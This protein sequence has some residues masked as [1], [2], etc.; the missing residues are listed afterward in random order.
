[1]GM[2]LVHV[3]PFMMTCPDVTSKQTTTTTE[4]IRVI[5]HQIKRLGTPRYYTTIGCS[6]GRDLT[7][8]DLK[9][10]LDQFSVYRF[11]PLEKLPIT[12]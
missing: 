11:T 2:N 3:N 6:N 4:Q 10:P 1:M 9:I 12:A 8:W 5:L 7:F